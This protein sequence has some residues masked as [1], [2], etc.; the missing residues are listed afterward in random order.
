MSELL[1][2]CL[3][4]P[5]AAVTA[6]AFGA[7]ARKSALIAALVSLIGTLVLAINFDP[8]ASGYQFV[9][10]T[11]PLALDSFFNIQFAVGLDG[12]NLPLVLLTS[13]VG[14][15]AILAVPSRISSEENQA[16]EG[17]YFINLLLILFGAMGAF[18]SLDLFYLYIFHEVALIPTFLLMGYWGNG[19][20][21]FSATQLALYLMTGSLILLGGIFAFYFSM[22]EG[23]QTMD[24]REMEAVMDGKA[25]SAVLPLLV[26]GFGILVSLFPFH[27]WAPSAYANSP[28][29]V[30]ML[31][32]GVLKKFGI[33]G[34][35]RLAVPFLPEG[36]ESWTNVFCVLL[37]MNVLYVGLVTIHQKKLDFL[38]GYSSV[39]HMGYLFLGL[40]SMK[41]I[42]LSGVILL[43]VGHGLSTALLFGLAGEIRDRAGTLEFSKLGGL[44]TKAPLLSFLFMI[45]AMASIGLPSLANFSGEILIYFGAWEAGLYWVT[46]MSVLGIVISAVYMLRAVRSVF[47]GELS[48][49]SGRVNDLVQWKE[50]I[51]Y[52]ILVVGLILVGIYPKLILKWSE[53]LFGA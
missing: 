42:G 44:A 31:H 43:M 41:A 36:M 5:L 10:E 7:P 25:Q 12:I 49:E 24:L 13:V 28:A 3:A 18:A 30:A 27:S 32:A 16:G 11:E 46:A 6:I 8:T 37:L 33:Y 52:L 51:P 1:L 35:L 9:T 45:G 19:D 48:P 23:M 38:L 53:T 17:G 20:K 22:P 47:Y 2:I 26:V 29:P 21:R 4:S 50:R 14:L 34:L 15:A 39:M 40:F